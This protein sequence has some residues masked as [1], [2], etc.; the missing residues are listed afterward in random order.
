MPSIQKIIYYYP[1]FNMSPFFTF[2]TKMII[3][4]TVSLYKVFISS[5]LLNCRNLNIIY[6]FVAYYTGGLLWRGIFIVLEDG[7]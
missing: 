2:Y 1:Y 3:F 5:K 7:S 4:F 6:I